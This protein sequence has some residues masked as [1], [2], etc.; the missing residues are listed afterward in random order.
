MRISGVSVGKVK[1]IELSDDGLADATIEIEP[2]YAPIP[3]DTQAILRQKTLLGETYVELTPGDGEAPLIPEG[4]T[5]TPRR[6]PTR[7][8][9]TRS[10]GPSTS[11]PG[12]RSGPGWWTPPVA[13]GRGADLNAALGNLS[14]FAQRADDLLRMLDSQQLAVGSC[15]PTA[16]RPS[17]RSASGRAS[18]VR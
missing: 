6:S 17:T 9:S 11:R 14:P 3:A 10:S 8:S 18:S 13:K 2:K 16:A 4:G 12:T 7:S 1:A 15:S 5:C